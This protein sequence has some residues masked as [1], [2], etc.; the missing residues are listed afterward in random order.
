MQ[1]FLELYQHYYY[2]YINN[3][4]LL[5]IVN[6]FKA[7]FSLYMVFMISKSASIFKSQYKLKI[8]TTNKICARH[9]I[10]I[11]V[12]RSLTIYLLYYFLLL[13]YL[14]LLVLAI[15]ILASISFSLTRLSS[16]LLKVSNI[17]FS[18]AT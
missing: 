16:A 5:K 17:F 9:T 12:E 14:F 4:L 1:T 10:L 7:K 18:L 6:Y 8:A 2:L 3:H 11:A 13:S 15:F